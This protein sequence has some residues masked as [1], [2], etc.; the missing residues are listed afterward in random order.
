V[1]AV[2]AHA[3]FGGIETTVAQLLAKQ[4]LVLND[5]HTH[6]ERERERECVCVSVYIYTYVSM[7]IYVY[8]SSTTGPA[9]KQPNQGR[10]W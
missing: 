4:P 9:A 2:C 8:R 5:L 6:R 1:D 7:Y 10:W 3:E